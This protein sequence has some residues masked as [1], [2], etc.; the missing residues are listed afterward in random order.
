MSRRAC[1]GCA[2]GVS[3][4]HSVPRVSSRRV[5]DSPGASRS[6]MAVTHQR[7]RVT[8]A[9]RRTA[10]APGAARAR[11]LVDGDRGRP[12]RGGARAVAYADRDRR[13]GANTCALVT[14]GT[15]RCWGA[16]GGALGNGTLRNSVV[17]VTVTGID[18]ATGIAVGGGQACAVLA[19]GTVRC[20]GNNEYGQLGNG[21]EARLDR[22]GQ[23]AR[24]RRPPSRCAG[25]RPHLRAAGRWRGCLLGVQRVD[26]RR[27]L[28]SRLAPV[29][30]DGIDDGVALAAGSPIRASSV[31]AAGSRAGAQ[32]GRPAGRRDAPA[33][34]DPDRG[35][36]DDRCHVDR[37]RG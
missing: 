18:T 33:S 3:S 13:R 5:V 11:R 8:G 10:A 21:S 23:G 16:N 6:E 2:A 20:W 4:R 37:R 29:P 26:R 28:S 35:G 12:E 36:R 7:P 32:R 19:D 31:P 1:A 9:A 24:H 15:V 17:P 14:D 25:R 34:A 22:A 30:V 27:I